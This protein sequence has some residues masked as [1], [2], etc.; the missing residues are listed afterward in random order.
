[1]EDS[2]ANI[3]TALPVSLSLF[4]FISLTLPSPYFVDLEPTQTMAANGS[5]EPALTMTVVGP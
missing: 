4:L 3:G 5:L 2:V 1:M